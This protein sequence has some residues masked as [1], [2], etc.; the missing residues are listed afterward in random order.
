VIGT[1]EQ[2]RR[3]IEDLQRGV[4]ERIYLDHRRHHDIGALGLFG[5]L[6]EPSRRAGAP[7]PRRRTRA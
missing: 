5:P 7:G 4:A 3:R 1:V 2:A 6:A